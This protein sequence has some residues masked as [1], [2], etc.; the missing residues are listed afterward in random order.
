MNVIGL[1]WLGTLIF[2]KIEL[3]SIWCE[4]YALAP[5]G[6]KNNQCHFGDS[7]GFKGSFFR[8]AQYMYWLLGRG[9]KS[10]H[11]V[12]WW[13][14]LEWRPWSYEWL[15]SWTYQTCTQVK[16]MI[17]HYH[18]NRLRNG[19]MITYSAILFA[20]ILYF[21]TAILNMYIHSSYVPLYTNVKPYK[22]MESH[23]TIS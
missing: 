1:F 10:T 13:H 16:W 22:F 12:A 7:R 18:E 9:K 17:N 19:R 5:I 23:K 11:A 6:D 2:C 15:W 4:S 21:C 14:W 20:L 3:R 8:G